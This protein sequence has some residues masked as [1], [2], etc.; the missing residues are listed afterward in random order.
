MF[1]IYRQVTVILDIRQK[2]PVCACFSL[3][4][5]SKYKNNQKQ[6]GKAMNMETV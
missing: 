1:S 5:E 3:G 6:K 2:W 4:L